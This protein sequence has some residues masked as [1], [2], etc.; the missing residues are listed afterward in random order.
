MQRGASIY[1]RSIHN[2]PFERLLMK[3]LEGRVPLLTQREI[4]ADDDGS[5]S[6]LLDMWCNSKDARGTADAIVDKYA[7][8]SRSYPVRGIDVVHVM[9]GNAS[10]HTRDQYGSDVD[11]KITFNVVV[12]VVNEETLL[13][14]VEEMVKKE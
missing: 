7:E 3:N 14:R 9:T 1:A 13:K 4:S 11:T 5:E 2:A 12:V 6:M 10:K 8:Y